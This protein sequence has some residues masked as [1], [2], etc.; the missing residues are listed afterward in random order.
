MF[1]GKGKIEN[2]MKI[3]NIKNWFNNKEAT[4]IPLFFLIIMGIWGF[5]YYVH[6]FDQKLLLGDEGV[7]L[8][9]AWRI[10]YGDVPHRDFWAV[11]PP[12]SFLPT[13]FLFKIFGQSIFIG[14]LLSLILAFALIFLLNIVIKKVAVD[15]SLRFL[16]ISLLI[17]FGVSYWPLP[18]HHW[19]CDIFC[20]LSVYFLFPSSATILTGGNLPQAPPER[21]GEKDFLP[22][23]GRIKEGFPLV[24]SGLFCGLA[25]WTLQDQGGY[26][27]ILLTSFLLFNLVKQKDVSNLKPQKAIA[28]F[29][30]GFILAT[31]PFLLWLLPTA[32]VSKLFQD[33]VLFP[34][35]SYHNLEGHKFDIFSGWNQFFPILSK[36]AFLSAPIYTLSL[37][38]IAIFLFVL[39][40]ISI[41]SFIYAKLTKSDGEKFFLI[42]AL[43]I[44]GF[45][46]A[47][48]RWSFTNIVWALPLLLPSLSFL[49]VEGKLRKSAKIVSYFLGITALLF[50]V[51]F[52]RLSSP[53]RMESICGRAGC[54]RTFKSN[55]SV[56]VKNA[57]SFLEINSKEGE[58]LF[59]AGFNS[60]INFLTQMKNPTPFNEFVSYHTDKQFEELKRAII[61]KRVDW[62]LIPK[63]K[64]LPNEKIEKFVLENYNRVYENNFCKIYKIKN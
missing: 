55:Y 52:F 7:A 61:E 21:R 18:S 12:F 42:I 45:L 53:E 35:A 15:F 41:F 28:F 36:G 31:I 4:N 50:S 33:L 20:L 6:I 37:T 29:M 27:F 40:I 22:F 57:V 59:C 64:T 13:A 3:F 23:Q 39:P 48:H 34:L 14:R 43:F 10:S 9:N 5:V 30:G 8:T 26:L 56:S 24:L 16:S 2:K 60:L 44:A 25:V 51:S 46:T 38:I 49:F 47:L 58:T 11:E 1:C 32:G 62:V 54:V 19:W 63:D 17:P